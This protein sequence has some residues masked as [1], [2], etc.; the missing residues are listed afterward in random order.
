M[1]G[2]DVRDCGGAEPWSAAFQSET[3]TA[4]QAHR[5]RRRPDVPGV[6]APEETAAEERFPAA[7]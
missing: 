2:R 4:T 5:S 7:R 3:E 1:S 6:D